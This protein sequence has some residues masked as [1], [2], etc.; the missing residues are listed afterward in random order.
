MESNRFPFGRD[1]WYL[2]IRQFAEL[3]GL[4]VR[5]V[6]HQIAKGALAAFVFDVDEHGHLGIFKYV[7]QAQGDYRRVRLF[8]QRAE[9]NR[10]LRT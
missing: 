2:T 7:P 6:H 4:N 1:N 5:Q 8:I 3:A 9:A 10:Y